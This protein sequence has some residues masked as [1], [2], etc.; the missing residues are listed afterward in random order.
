[1]VEESRFVLKEV[2]TI[3]LDANAKLHDDCKQHADIIPV[4]KY[5]RDFR[6]IRV[7]AGQRMG[8]TVAIEQL[9]TADDL[10]VT[11][12]EECE[13]HM[14]AAQIKPCVVHKDYV[15]NPDRRRALADR[16]WARIWIDYA[17]AW[18]FTY[19]ALEHVYADL[20]KDADQQ[21]ILVG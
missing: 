1:M 9:A 14:L 16:R 2:L 18:G 3:L 21:F 15:L 12:G 19:E 7:G 17:S 6:T 10:I 13:V 8:Q 11:Y 4:H 20:V 5:V